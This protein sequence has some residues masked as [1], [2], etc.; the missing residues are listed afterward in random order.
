MTDTSF[1]G[2]DDRTRRWI[3]YEQTVNERLIDDRIFSPID[4]R[5]N[6]VRREFRP[7]RRGVWDQEVVW[8]PKAS[9]RAYGP[10]ADELRAAFAVEIPDGRT[11]MFLHPQPPAAMRRLA[12]SNGREALAGVAATP[13][14]SYRSVVVWQRSGR[15]AAAVL[16]LSLGAIIGGIRRRFTELYIAQSVVLS[17]VLATVPRGDRER[18]G[19]DW[20]S[21]PCG[22]VD[23]ESR[24]G[25]VLR[26]LPQLMS[27]P[28][29]TTVMPVFSLISRD[30]DRVPLLV[31]LM[32]R[33]MRRPEEFVIDALIRPYVNAEAYLL[34]EQGVQHEGHTQNV[35]VEVDPSERLTGRL[36]LRDLSDTSVN[37]AFCMA[38]GKTLPSFAPGMLPR[39]APFGIAANAGD[40]HT[41][42]RRPRILRGF[43]TVE[44]Y[45]LSG[46]VW[47]INASVA[48]YVAGYDSKRVEQR[49]LELWQSAAMQY[50]KVKPLF[51][52]RPSGLATDE[53]VAYFLRQVDWRALGARPACLPAAAEPLLGEGRTRRR[54][55]P[56]YD[57][58]TSPWG[59]LFVVDGLPAFF[60][61]AF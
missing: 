29:T 21:E 61:S 51:R 31:R 14:A 6:T 13:T 3:R 36:I 26:R 56:V 8:V 44:R 39:G 40:H 38:K 47:P 59:D 43:D 50:L 25:W 24:H 37:I 49:Y 33:S 5:S 52:K 9:A 55:G 58:L 2:L 48:R 11:A 12:R 53:A 57:R 32:Q 1:H 54:S 28:G 16:K 45:G 42:L 35:L 7:E 20:F 15:A 27:E 30:G 19:L 60:R 18:L 10:V 41:N 23:A 34:F 17:S 4:H 22:A 46:F